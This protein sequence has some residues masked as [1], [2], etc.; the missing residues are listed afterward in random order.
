MKA[1]V[2]RKY[3]PPEVL[4]MEE[5]DIPVPKD[6]Q[7]RIKI[8]A[9]TVTL[10]DCELRRFSLPL[11]IWLP[12]RLYMGV[13][14]P[15]IKI[16]G[17]ELSGEIDEIGNNVTA[18]KQGDPVFAP[19]KMSLGAH[20]EY[21]CL[22]A[23]FVI[24]H[25][26]PEI[27]FIEAAS[28]PTGGLNALYF[29]RKA[30]I[31]PG[32]KILINGAGGTIGTYAVQLAKEMGAEVTAVDTGEKLGVLR[33]IGADHVMDYTREDFTQDFDTY[34]AI[35]EI[36]CKSSISACLRSIKSHGRLVLG[37]PN[38]SSMFRS[39]WNNRKS[40]KKIINALAPYKNEDLN[41]LVE[42][43]QA[44]KLKPVIDRT[45]P[46]EDMIDAHRYVEIGHKI[47]HVGITI[48]HL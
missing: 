2:H 16:L 32:H 8:H 35:I 47:G 26:P 18:F 40:S 22:P 4:K 36:V 48:N 25:K 45:F 11:W 19:T 27:S 12:L 3:G 46:L 17:Q 10:G 42:L 1:V 30:N 37:N 31:L 5:V 41:Y 44:G 29:V 13:F 23:D 39:L 20:A 38:L 34:D 21:I 33:S 9:S 14:R 15:R 7:V 43:I 6:N 28:I 24:A